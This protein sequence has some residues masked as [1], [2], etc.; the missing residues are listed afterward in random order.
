LDAH[1]NPNLNCIEV[2][3]PTWAEQNWTTSNNS[4]DGGVT[5][6]T[7]CN[8]S[9]GCGGS[10]CNNVAV[11]DTTDYFVSDVNFENISPG[12]SLT[13][14][15]T[16]S[17]DLGCDS[18]IFRY[19]K[20]IFNPN[21]YTDSIVTNDTNIIN[22]QDTS[23][24]SI[25]DTINVYD[26]VTVDI[27]DTSYVTIEDTVTTYQTIYD[28]I[29]TYDTSY[30]S[31][32]VTDTL[33]IDITI[34]PP[35]GTIEITNTI[36]IYPNPANE[37]ITID[38]GNFSTMTNYELK[39]VNTLGQEVFSN[40]ISVPLFVIPVST[41]GAEGTYFVQVLDG[42]GNLVVTKYLILN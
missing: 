36:S 8:Y 14:V 22:I 33:L 4:V 41:L 7:N 39:I 31:I 21:Y 12:Y 42:D 40:F 18:L 38:N 37:F 1:N 17:N 35:T 6:S 26:T 3:D 5:F 16:L 2:D 13:T 20:Y 29:N 15:D 23:Y 32:A 11:S 34:V 9:I 19:N 10:T 30:V 24:V 27:V 25:Y 28:T